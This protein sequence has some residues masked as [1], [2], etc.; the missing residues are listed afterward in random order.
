MSPRISLVHQFEQQQAE[1]VLLLNILK[2]PPLKLRNVGNSP[3]DCEIS[4]L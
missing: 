2:K 1:T 4:V 3:I